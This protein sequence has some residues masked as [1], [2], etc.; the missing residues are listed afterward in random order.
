MDE[1]SHRIWSAS[2]LPQ[3]YQKY[4][5]SQGEWFPHE[6]E[7]VKYVYH[8]HT[9]LNCLEGKAMAESSE[10]CRNPSVVWIPC[11]AMDL[12]KISPLLWTP[13]LNQPIN[14]RNLLISVPCR[15][16]LQVMLL[17]MMRREQLPLLPQGMDQNI[18]LG[19]WPAH[20]VDLD[21]PRAGKLL[22]SAEWQNSKLFSCAQDH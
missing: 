3:F 5:D 14:L 21:P 2:S 11:Y 4:T 8:K 1:I 16:L 17:L 15:G 10:L 7:K 18:P 9:T 22:H 19:P 13:R 20:P 12:N 6:T